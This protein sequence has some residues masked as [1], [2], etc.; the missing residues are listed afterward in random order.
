MKVRVIYDVD[1][2]C[3]KNITGYRISC[4]LSDSQIGLIK[5]YDKQGVV[6]K[7]YH[8]S[9]VYYME[10]DLENSKASKRRRKNH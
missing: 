10:S 2:T 6:V 3:V 5:V 7:A 1:G 4:Q 9:K 8:F